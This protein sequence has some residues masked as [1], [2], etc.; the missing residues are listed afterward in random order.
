ME[1]SNKTCSY[2]AY[3]DRIRLYFRG[4]KSLW[5]EYDIYIVIKYYN[6]NL[7]VKVE[8]AKI[9]LFL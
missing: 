4:K 3:M 2:L 6:C 8:W 1:N 7:T 9:E 5:Y